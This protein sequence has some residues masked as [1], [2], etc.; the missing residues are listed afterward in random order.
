LSRS[1]AVD[2]DGE[3]FSILF[4]SVSALSWRC[5]GQILPHGAAV[6]LRQHLRAGDDI[7]II[8][9]GSVGCHCC[10]SSW[11]LL[12]ASSIGTSPDWILTINGFAFGFGSG[13]SP[14][15]SRPRSM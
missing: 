11:M 12:F 5:A 6:S 7:V 4:F 8:E 9:V 13:S 2:A 3:A 14:S 10:A 1:P 15:L